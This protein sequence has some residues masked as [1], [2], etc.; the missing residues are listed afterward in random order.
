MKVL[1]TGGAGYIGSHVVVELVK[2]GY[3]VVIFDNFSNASSNVPTALSEL[4]GVQIT[5]TSGDLRDASALE[6]VFSDHS[7]DAV[8]H[9]AGLKSV[10]ESVADPLMY[11]DNNVLGSLQ[12]CKSMRK[13]D[14]KR[15][16]FSSSATVYG[17]P[18]SVPIREDAPAVNP[19]NPYGMT[20]VICEKMVLDLCRSDPS[21]SAG[22]LRY[23]NPV[24]AH[25]SGLIGEDPKGQP[26]NLMPLLTNAAADP[27][28]VLEIYG[29][30]YPTKDGTGVR[31]YIHVCDLAAGHVA[32][33][34]RC[35]T[36]SQHFIANLGTGNGFSVLEV[37]RAFEQACGI[38]IAYQIAPRRPG[39]VAICYADTS[40]ATEFLNWRAEKTLK[41]MC[42]DSWR[43][44]EQNS[45]L[46]SH[47]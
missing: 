32:A 43:W 45:L 15:L 4:C 20:K 36:D 28:A 31:D 1:V 46:G 5:V 12:L 22:I 35:S 24:G 7:I 14:V 21:F 26:A 19:T 27:T 34:N 41:D 3:E 9:F 38:K 47:M 37:I 8:M 13:Y 11:Y 29:C 16:V 18:I 39:D 25:P 30:D 2:H 10:A 6:C 33:L 40:Y 44:Q 23:F 17:D 42:L